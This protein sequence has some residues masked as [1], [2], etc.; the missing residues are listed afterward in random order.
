MSSSTGVPSASTPIGTRSR[1]LPP[2]CAL[3]SVGGSWVNRSGMPSRRGQLDVG[4]ER[5]GG[6]RRRAHPVRREQPGQRLGGLRLHRVR[7]AQ[8]VR[9]SLRRCGR[10]DQ[11]DRCRGSPTAAGSLRPGRHV[12]CLVQVDDHGVA[13]ALVGEAVP[14]GT[15]PPSSSTTVY[16]SS[17]VGDASG[18]NGGRSANSSPSSRSSFAH[19]VGDQPAPRRRRPVS[20]GCRACGSHLAHS[21]SPATRLGHEDDPQLLRRVEGRELAQ[22]R[23]DHRAGRGRVAAQ[24]HPGVGPQIHRDRLVRHRGVGADEAAQRVRA[25]R[26]EILDRLGRQRRETQCEPLLADRDPHLAEV[27][28]RGAAFPQPGGAHHRRQRQRL[29]MTPGLS[30]PL[31]LGGLAYLSPGDRQVAQV[32][33]SFVPDPPLAVAEARSSWLTTIPTADTAIMPIAT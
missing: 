12:Q 22:H 20:I 18:S 5:F 11:L 28:V 33:A 15:R 29:G 6:L 4:G 23:A 3:H 7:S 16:G 8:A 13:V 30:V 21:H 19:A 10:C 1:S 14:A 25:E 24:Q 27:G 17:R 9:T 31:L 32:V 26:F 2:V